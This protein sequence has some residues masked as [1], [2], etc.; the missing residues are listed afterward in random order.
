MV[1]IPDQPG[2]QFDLYDSLGLYPNGMVGEAEV[3]D[4]HALA[5]EAI[6]PYTYDKAFIP[7]WPTEI[8]INRARN[9]FLCSSMYSGQGRHWRLREIF[10]T[11]HEKQVRVLQYLEPQGAWESRL[12]ETRTIPY[13]YPRPRRCGQVKVQG[14]IEKGGLG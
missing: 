9:W 6:D 12:L 1:G 13:G 8:E 10:D 5:L 7:K 4:A 14:Q 3:E 2:L 11:A